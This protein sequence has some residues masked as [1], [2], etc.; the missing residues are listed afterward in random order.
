MFFIRIYVVSFS[1]QLSLPL[2]C[3]PC[4]ALIDS[5]C[6]F[7]LDLLTTIFT[8][9]DAIQRKLTF[10]C[11]F[12]SPA[13]QI[14]PLSNVDG[15]RGVVCTKKRD[16]RTSIHRHRSLSFVGDLS[17][18]HLLSL[19]IAVSLSPLY[20]MSPFLTQL[21]FYRTFRFPSSPQLIFFLFRNNLPS[22]D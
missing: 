13:S 11:E 20:Q 17:S 12:L 7:F 10:G 15:R 1:F 4:L 21:S 14:T 2:Y 9:A 5:S 18:L 6:H 19:V 22:N 16:V 8:V 3:H